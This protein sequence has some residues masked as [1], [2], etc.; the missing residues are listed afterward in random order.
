M[1]WQSTDIKPN[2]GDIVV[3]FLFGK[4]CSTN[5]YHIGKY[6]SDGDYI[7]TLDYHIPMIKLDSYDLWTKIDLPVIYIKN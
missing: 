2:N 5:V 3:C 6:T 4:T 7:K 1:K